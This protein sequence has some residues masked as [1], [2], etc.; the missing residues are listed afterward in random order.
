MGMKKVY[1][2]C[3]LSGHGTIAAVQRFSAAA[4]AEAL[5]MARETVK[6]SFGLAGFE[7]WEGGRKV[8]AEGASGSHTS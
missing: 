3:L 2:L 7:L 1:R 5:A 8:G 4:D 6:G